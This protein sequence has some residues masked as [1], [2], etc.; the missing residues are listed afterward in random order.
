[1]AEAALPPLSPPAATSGLLEVVRRRYLLRLLVRRAIDS[2]YQGTALGWTWSYLQPFV[3]FCMFY[4]LFQV[5]IGR[6]SGVENFA[7]HLF[8][9]MVLVHFFT[10]TFN[11]GTKSLVSNRGLIVKLPMPRELFPVSSMLVALW[12]TGPMLVIL[13][14][15][16]ALAGWRPDPVGLL[17]GLMGFALIGVLGLALSLFFSVANVFFRDFGKV[18]QTLTQFTTFSVPMIYPFTFVEQ[19]F[20]AAAEYYLL[21]PVA[22][23][24]LLIQRCFWTGT[25]SDP[26]TAV[27]VHLPDDLFARGGI[28]LGVS[29]LLLLLAQLWFMRYEKQVPERL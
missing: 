3:R 13:T 2:R 7:I 25:N 9:G 10:E 22:E 5:F 15:A 28:M 27:D 16:S 29:A 24:V 4:F 11:G 23:A 6:G 26:S 17:A 8:S 18:V 19:R 21:N 14:V 1:M 20:G 12:H